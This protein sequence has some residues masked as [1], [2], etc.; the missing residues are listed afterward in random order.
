MMFF[1]KHLKTVSL[2]MYSISMR[3]IN[4]IS[5][6]EDLNYTCAK[7]KLSKS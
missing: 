2:N 6:Y 3:D 5:D 1:G 4:T 7:F